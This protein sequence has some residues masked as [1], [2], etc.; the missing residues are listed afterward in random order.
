MTGEEAAKLLFR[1]VSRAAKFTPRSA[2][3]SH[4]ARERFCGFYIWTLIIKITQKYRRLGL[5]LTIIFTCAAREPAHNTGCGPLPKKKM[6][7]PGLERLI[8]SIQILVI[9]FKCPDK[10]WTPPPPPPPEYNWHALPLKT[11][12]SSVVRRIDVDYLQCNRSFSWSVEPDF[13][14]RP[15]LLR[16]NFIFTA[17]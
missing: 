13:H 9:I 12:C 10:N 14:L 6:E 17:H 16:L 1:H 8:K 15:L 3:Q 2:S 7:I 5:P 11:T 4:V